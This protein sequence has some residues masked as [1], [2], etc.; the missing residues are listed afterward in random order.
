MLS[1][2]VAAAAAAAAA[3]AEAAVA[4]HISLRNAK[5]CRSYVAG[6]K[7]PHQPVPA[8]LL[9]FLRV[10]LPTCKILFIYV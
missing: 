2:A 7:I 1:R 8:L 6:L 4:L 5:F 10:L 9:I 3:A